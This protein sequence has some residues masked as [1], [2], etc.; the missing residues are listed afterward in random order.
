MWHDL[1]NSMAEEEELHGSFA[2][3]GLFVRACCDAVIAGFAERFA[4]IFRDIIFAFRS[5]RRT[6]LFSLVIIATLAVAIGANAAVFSVLRAVVFAPL[7]YAE[8]QNLVVVHR[9]QGGF[10]L[11]A[12]SLPNAQDIREQ[13]RVFT[14]VAVTTHQRGTIT[15]VGKPRQLYGMQTT[16]PVFN[17]L[18]VHPEL[19]RFFQAG[20]EQPGSG[21]PIIVSDNLWRTAF[22]SDTQIIGRAMTLDAQ[23]YRVI[24]VAPPRFRFPYS[25]FRQLVD[26]DYWTVLRTDPKTYTR[27]SNSFGMIARLRPGITSAAATADVSRVIAG[28]ARRYPASNAT[29]TARL[30]P[31]T[32]VFIG[33]VRPLLFAAFGAVVGIV[34]IACANV[35]NLILSRSAARDR[36]L[37]IR[38]A[39]GATRRRIVSQILTE[40]LLLAIGSGILGI[41]L[42][43]ALINAF[44]AFNPLQIP[45]L[46]DIH[47]D[48][49]VVA[50]TFG[51]VALCAVASGIVPALALSRP[52][53]AEALKAAG[54][55]GDSSRGTRA[56]NAFVVLEIAI[57]VAL[58]VSSGL[59]VR[60]FATLANTPLGID[61]H[62]VSVASFAGLPQARYR[63]QAQIANFYRDS[64][65]RV[66]TIPGVLSAA[67]VVGTSP[68]LTRG[69][70]GPM[71]VEG[72]P[73]PIG[74]AVSAAFV[75]PQIFSAYGMELKAG[76]SFTDRDRLGAAPVAIVDEAFEHAYFRG[77]A[78][79]QWVNPF[80]AGRMTIVGVVANVRNSFASPYE[81][82]CYIPIQQLTFTLTDGV[83]LL[84]RTRPGVHLD[85][86]IAT[87]VTASDP[88]LAAAQVRSLQSFADEALT[89]TRF[90]ALLIG[91]LGLVALFLAVAGIYAVVSFGVA[92]R[93]QE[94]G[95][96]R[97]LGARGSAI[98]RNVL[99]RAA[100][101]A[102][103]GILGG[104]ILA[105]FAAGLV[106][107]Q[108][109]ETTTL[110]PL[111]YGIVILLVAF[112]AFLASLGPAMRAI[113][114]DPVVAL[115]QL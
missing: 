63:T 82:N 16:W 23:S 81:P 76:R 90:S 51:I 19:G 45:R 7:P 109:F 77:S 88:L 101:L 84:V 46:D 2:S 17:I 105:G 107:D 3:F 26:A 40:T 108:L 6:P 44:I 71:N 62:N 59:I 13:N 61:V 67:W 5:L 27:G 20:D 49:V 12:W 104:I 34:A 55:G 113:R 102:G 78:I 92:Q 15:G 87:A 9:L 89:Q 73:E 36:E 42:A 96:R 37:A 1:A 31:F 112:A 39:I 85:A 47:I 83:R 72:R 4:M 98:I 64:A 111:T 33:D 103:V 43:A 114:V 106:R 48:A 25:L 41:A 91:S 65:E 38:F 57:S 35:A 93:T 52:Q 69:F 58:V 100:R 54:R 24:G 14:D 75:G 50:Y 28:L 95:I 18:G 86:A 22:G 74:D 53:L 79:G 97:A 80:G 8:P 32:D 68:L 56:R 115:R 21:L 110:D 94:F 11:Q 10:D 70:N 66:R 60:S 99:A 30:V 29:L